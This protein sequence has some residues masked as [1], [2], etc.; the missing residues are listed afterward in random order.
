M[1]R[2]AGIELRTDSIP[3]EITFLSFC[4]LLEKDE[5]GEQIFETAKSHFN[6]SA[7]RIGKSTMVGA[8]FAAAPSSTKKKSVKLDPEIHQCMYGSQ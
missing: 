3:D 4:H 7:M 8:T 6:L 2:F 5:L 1:R